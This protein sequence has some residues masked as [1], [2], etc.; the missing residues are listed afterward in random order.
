MSLVINIIGIV[1]V[2]GLLFL[3]SE[4]KKTIKWK[5]IGIALAMQLIF[6]LFIV[7]VP[8]GQ[9]MI[10]AVSN[11]LDK[12]IAYGNEGISFVFGSLADSTSATGSIFFIQTLCMIVFFSGLFSALYYLG[13]LGFVIRIV[14]G[15]LGK[16]LGTSQ[17]ETFVAVAN[18]FLGQTEAPI[19]VR[20]FI[21]KMTRSE[22]FVVLVAGMGSVSGS[23]LVG[24]NLMG[25]PME[26]L[27]IACAMV[28]LSSLI[29]AKLLVPETEESKIDS[30][31]IDRKGTN[32]NLIEAV[33]GGA[34][35]GMQLAIN[36]A[37]SLIVFVG[38]I[39]LINGILG[40][41]GLSLQQILGWIFTPFAFLMGIAREDVQTVAQLLGTK[42]AVNEF[43][44]FSAYA[45]VAE[46][47]TPRASQMIAI[48]LAGFAN[49]A[50][51]A[52][53]VTGI[54]LLA[55]SKKRDISRIAFKAMFAG[56]TVSF[57]SA[58]IVGLFL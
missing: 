7:K 35:D 25:V 49:F 52:I 4:S 26:S 15:I 46:V 33:S 50:S 45:E 41:V 13:I 27:L 12:I 34:V 31:E 58:L 42:I 55:P 6:A 48:A 28:P 2:L 24:Y 43:V 17:A 22:L 57:F 5:A 36:I 53:C 8:L 16:V 54:S 40:I 1:V 51:I 14:G 39:A 11:V 9:D 47:L 19:L 29:V 10:L 32:S 44:A 3:C 23:I 21:D 37:A 38:L 56:A 30:I 20:Y 18:V